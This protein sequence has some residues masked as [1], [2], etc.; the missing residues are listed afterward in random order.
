MRVAVVN[1]LELAVVALKRLLALDP[2][3]ELA[4]VARDGAEAVARCRADR[5]DLLL[6]DLVMPGVDGVEATRRIMQESPCPILVVTATVEGNIGRVYHALGAGALDAVSGPTFGPDGALV[7][8]EPALRKLRSVAR[9]AR[10]PAPEP[11]LRRPASGAVA[12]RAGRPDRLV[13]L[14]ASTG[15]PQ[16]LL[17]VLAGFPAGFR[18]PVLVVQH[19]DADFVPGFVAWLGAQSGHRVRAAAA[20]DAPA[21]GEVLVACTRDHLVMGRAR[22][23]RY[24]RE[25]AE[26]P[27]RPSVD[28]F[29]TSLAAAWDRPGV[30]VLLTGMGQ[31]GARGL[32]ALR[33]AGW[34]TLAQDRDSSVVYG[35]PRAAL[36]S[37]AAQEA[38]GVA[39]LGA[40]I[41]QA[42]AEL[43]AREA[44]RP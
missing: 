10:G 4:W 41:A 6:M 14:G 27:Y 23:L 34:A 7:G 21:P 25:P 20:G 12:P 35:M 11:G 39:R 40:R 30:G 13:A 33:A 37:G 3:F 1:D 29:F 26:H 18:P 9:L 8:A 36:E 38:V 32:Q 22:T 17:E 15:G 43:D 16:A 2:A 5:P 42:Y 19:L 44:A 28:V 24:E 31:D